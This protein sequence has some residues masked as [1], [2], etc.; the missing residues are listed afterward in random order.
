MQKGTPGWE[1]YLPPL[2]AEV[3]KQRALFGYQQ[4]VAKGAP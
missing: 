3:I 1:Q 4:A 2:A